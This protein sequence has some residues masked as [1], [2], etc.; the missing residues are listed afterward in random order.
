MSVSPDRVEIEAIFSALLE[1]HGPQQWW[2][3]DSHFEMI[4]GAILTQNTAWTNVEKALRNLRTADVWSFS[5]TLALPQDELAALIRPSGY[6]NQKA[7]KIQTFARFLAERFGGDI[8]LL[9]RL[10]MP[11]LRTALLSLWGIGEET[12]DDII[13]YA[14]RKPSFV[15]DNYTIRLAARLGW[16]ADGS[17]YGDYQRLFTSRLAPDAEL[18][19]EYHAL[20]DR[21]CHSTCKKT[22]LCSDCC[23]QEICPTGRANLSGPAH[24]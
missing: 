8:D 18:F 2:P 16:H 11:D 7:R 15:I 14:A 4:T 6:Y 17:G 10:E 5:A 13:L 24:G 3:A 21:H 22:P 1:C 12:A 9:F 20:I 23:L 19:G